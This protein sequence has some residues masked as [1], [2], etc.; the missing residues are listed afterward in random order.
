MNTVLF[1]ILLFAVPCIVSY[2]TVSRVGRKCRNAMIIFSALG[3]ITGIVSI[4][5][6]VQTT[7]VL[8]MITGN[9]NLEAVGFYSFYFVLIFAGVF[10]GIILNKNKKDRF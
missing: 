1:L 3:I 2:L 4:N 10:T 5:F 8:S 6:H 7:K 9:Y